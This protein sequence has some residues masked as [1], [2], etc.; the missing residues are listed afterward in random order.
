MEW[1]KNMKLGLHEI[2]RAQS[3]LFRR[4]WRFSKTSIAE[5]LILTEDGAAGPKQER[6]SQPVMAGR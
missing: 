5:S 1:P 2:T 6:K 3:V 4:L